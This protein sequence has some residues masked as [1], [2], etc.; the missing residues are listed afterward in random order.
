MKGHFLTQVFNPFV[1]KSSYFNKKN[2]TLKHFTSLFIIQ[3]IALVV[4]AQNYGNI[5]FIENKGQWDKSVQYKGSVSNGTFF[6]RNGGFTV[7]QHNPRD[8]AY[9]ARFLHGFN[10][11]GRPVSPND[12][13]ILHSHAYHVDFVG[14]SPGLRTLPDKI[15]PTYNNYF[16]GNDASRW[17]GDCHIFQAITLKDVYP[18][19]DVRYYTDN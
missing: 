8:F 16:K 10:P 11:D 9:V 1:V 7:V 19:V 14:A 4:S 15:I 18:D 17:A 5:E 3:F 2:L 6:I 12:R 13:I